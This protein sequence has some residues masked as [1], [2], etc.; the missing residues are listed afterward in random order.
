MSYEPKTWVTGEVITADDLNLITPLV[1]P[2][3]FDE[4]QIDESQNGSTLHTAEFIFN[5]LKSG[6]VG[7]IRFEDETSNLITYEFIEEISPDGSGGYTMLTFVYNFTTEKV[8][9]KSYAATT[10]SDKFTIDDK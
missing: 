6:R 4:S 5:A 2:F 3:V 7:F 9:T 10:G 8:S 1:E